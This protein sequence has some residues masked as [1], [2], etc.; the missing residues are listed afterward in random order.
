MTP[1]DKQHLWNALLKLGNMPYVGSGYPAYN[2]VKNPATRG[3][4]YVWKYAD[5]RGLYNQLI[6]YCELGE[7]EACWRVLLGYKTKIYPA[8]L[9]KI[10]QTL[11]CG[12]GPTAPIVTTTAFTNITIIGNADGGGDVTNDGG[13]SVTARGICYSINPNPTLADSFT[14][15]GTGTGIFISALSLIPLDTTYYVRAYATNGIGTSYGNQVT[16]TTPPSFVYINTQYW[17][18]KNL[19]V[20]TYRN[21]DSI[22]FATNTVDWVAYNTTKTGAWR[23]YDDDPSTELIYGKWYNSY[24]MQ[25]PRNLA[26][27]GYHIPTIYEYNVLDDYL[28]SQ[29]EVM[30]NLKNISLDVWTP[31]NT[32]ASNLYLYEAMP[33]GSIPESA[34]SKGYNMADYG[35]YWIYGQDPLY[36]VYSY[37]GFDGNSAPYGGATTPGIGTTIRLIDNASLVRGQ[38]FGGGIL[39]ENTGTEGIT[40][41]A[42]AGNVA[43]SNLVFG[44]DVWGCDGVLIG[45]TDV[46]TGYANTQ[47]MGLSFCNTVSDYIS[48]GLNYYNQYNDWYIPAS[49]EVLQQ[50]QQVPEYEVLLDP[51]LSYWTSTEVDST[52]AIV[53][54]NPSN[55]PGGSNW[56]TRAVS[57]SLFYPFLGMRK[58]VL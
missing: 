6:K 16:L 1:T 10:Y 52:T 43:I 7:S 53:I 24:A 32:D 14:V 21:G 58:Q 18:T 30:S 20:T 48:Q 22:P 40:G 15:D 49:D 51:T 34:I 54:Y 31:P 4:R 39:L 45:A 3:G 42:E 2:N 26:P 41:Y 36:P 28:T 29:S 13:D 37:F 47:V 17:A 27:N 12:V 19:N 9:R 33:G 8:Y 56:T 46:M 11:N 57:K 50:I 5:M 38:G 25:D 35:Y 55:S 44:D 23:Y